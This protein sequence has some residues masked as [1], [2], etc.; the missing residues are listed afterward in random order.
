MKEAEQVEE[1]WMGSL[2]STL[3]METF[4][5]THSCKSMLDINPVLN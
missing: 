2:I 4:P 5:P 1:L 3:L